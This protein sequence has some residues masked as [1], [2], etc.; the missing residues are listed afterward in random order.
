MP[1]VQPHE[2]EQTGL[3]RVG[4][5]PTDRLHW[6]RLHQAKQPPRVRGRHA[7]DR[8]VPRELH[9]QLG[10]HEPGPESAVSPRAEGQTQS[11]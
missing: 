7:A 11:G 2:Y 1:W 8:G 9:G 5:V 4:R 10:P 6:H 3:A